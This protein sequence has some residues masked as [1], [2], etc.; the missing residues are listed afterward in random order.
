MKWDISDVKTWGPDKH[1]PGAYIPDAGNAR[2]YRTGGWRTNRPVR[3]D[4][5]CTQCLFCYY[6]CPDSSVI[7][8]EKKVV[9]FD[10]DHCKGCGICATECPVD[11]ITMHP[12]SEFRGVTE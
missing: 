10:Y 5:T 9:D 2:L 6:F 12:E 1:N 8:E 7:V 11:A 4:E 3:D